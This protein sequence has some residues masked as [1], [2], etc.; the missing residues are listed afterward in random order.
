[1]LKLFLFYQKVFRD[2]LN[3]NFYPSGCKGV[4]EKATEQACEMSPCPHLHEAAW[5]Q[6]AKA[7]LGVKD[8]CGTVQPEGHTGQHTAGLLILYVVY[9]KIDIFINI[10][11]KLGLATLTLRPVMVT[12]PQPHHVFW[13]LP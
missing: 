4:G 9:L 12:S 3:Q 5:Y 11:Q 8:T 10:C 2:F 1:M 7:K 13:G 6:R